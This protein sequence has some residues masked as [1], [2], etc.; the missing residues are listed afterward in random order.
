MYLSAHH[1]VSPVRGEGINAFY[2][3]HGYDWDADVPPQMF[4]TVRRRKK[5]PW[6]N[7]VVSQEWSTPLITGLVPVARVVQ[8]LLALAR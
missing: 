8:E 3:V 1:V 2:Y 5:W 6:A 4:R 7:D